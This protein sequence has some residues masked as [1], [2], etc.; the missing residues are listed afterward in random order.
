MLGSEGSTES[1]IFNLKSQLIPPQDHQVQGHIRLRLQ[2]ELQLQKQFPGGFTPHT[3][4]QCA[5]RRAAT[6]LQQLIDVCTKMWSSSAEPA[7]SS[8]VEP[9]DVQLFLYI[10]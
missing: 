10:L 2:V 1:F 5:W 6:F 3:L 8:Q 4:D 9:S 7:S